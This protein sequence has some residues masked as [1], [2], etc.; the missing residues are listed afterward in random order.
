MSEQLEVYD[1]LFDDDEPQL[2]RRVERTV[3]KVVR[4]LTA[5]PEDADTIAELLHLQGVRGLRNSVTGCPLSVYFAHNGFPGLE[6]GV[7]SI[8][9]EVWDVELPRACKTFVRRFDRGS[10]KMLRVT[11]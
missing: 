7:Q 11:A 5:L 2:R 10:Y 8:G 9:H 1:Y 6:V 4:L 3:A